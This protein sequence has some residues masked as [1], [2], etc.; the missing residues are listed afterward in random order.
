VERRLGGAVREYLRR[1]AELT[2]ARETAR[3]CRERERKVCHEALIACGRAASQGK[4][5]QVPP[6]CNPAQC[7]AQCAEEEGALGQR[8]SGAAELE[9]KL[10]AAQEAAEVQRR[11]V[12]RAR[13]AYYREP[14]TVEEAVYGEY[15]Y[16]VELHRLTVMASVTERLMDLAK[17][18]AVPSPRTED[19]AS[20][21]EDVAH[22]GYEKVGV[23][24]DPV[25]LRSEV[26]LRVDAGDRAME[27]IAE[28]VKARFDAYRQRRVE[29]ARRGMVRP[30]AEDVVEAAVRALLLTADDPPQDILLPLLK[31]RG[32]ENPEALFGR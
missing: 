15:P 4:P 18:G 28:R 11:E 9:R 16:D 5:G 23:L 21:H 13:D 10:E 2:Q 12:Q 25:Q 17:V 7:N 27:A 24:A 30:S 14:P 22:K 20:W 26:E 31:A 8:T 3:R 1:Q 32:L 29:D 19:Y 6:E